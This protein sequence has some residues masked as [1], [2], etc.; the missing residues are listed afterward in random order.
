MTDLTLKLEEVKQLLDYANELPTKYGAPL[1]TFINQISQKRV[2][3][4]SAS[5]DPKGVKPEPAI[6][7]EQ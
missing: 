6:A 4:A 2:Q 7:E 1:L 5:V 3:E